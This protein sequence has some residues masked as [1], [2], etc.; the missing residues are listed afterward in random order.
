MRIVLFLFL[1][2]GTAAAQE[3]S[4]VVVDSVSHLPLKR[5]I[6]S[7]NNNQTSLSQQRIQAVVTDD[8]GAFTFKLKPGRYRF[9]AMRPDYPVATKTV[10][11]DA[12]EHPSPVTVEMPPGAVVS[13]RVLD[14]DGDPLGGCSVQVLPP[15]GPEAIDVLRR[16]VLE[17][18]SSTARGEYPFVPISVRHF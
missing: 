6:V 2:A 17:G 5:V 3:V 16:L 11:V 13:G 12:S 8:S 9:V 10:T 14:E 15:G 18:L 7:P 4:G 1:L